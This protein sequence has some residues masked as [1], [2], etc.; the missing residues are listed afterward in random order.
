VPGGR[1]RYDVKALTYLEQALAPTLR[2]GQIVVMGQPLFPQGQ[3]NEGDHLAQGLRARLTAALLA[4]LQ[5]NRAGV[6]EGEVDL[7]ASR[8]THP[9]SAD[10]GDGR[11]ALRGVGSGH[12]GVLRA[13]RLQLDGST[14]K[15]A[16]TRVARQGRAV[17]SFSCVS[18]LVAC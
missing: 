17:C 11:G 6:L 3:E 9:R 1:G 18:P 8:G 12:P 7:A 10:R 13:L 14:A 15:T 16:A 5:P 4:G 2:P